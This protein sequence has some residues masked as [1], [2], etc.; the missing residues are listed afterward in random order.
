MSNN[1]TISCI[2]SVLAWENTD[3]N[4]N[5]FAEKLNNL[6][7]DSEIV[8][9]PE[10][11]TT[12]FS[13]NPG[14]LA[15]EMNCKSFA[16]MK[17]QSA[18]INKVIIGSIIIQDNNNYFNRLIAMFPNGEYFTYDKRHLFRMGKEHEK[19]TRG[20]N[21][22]VFKY[23]GWRICPLICYDLRFPVWSRNRD[24]YDMLIYIAN[25]PD[26]RRE[27][28]K[29]LL[30]ARAL[31][32]QA[33]VVGV[34]RVGEDGEGLRYSGDTMVIGP[35]GQIL[36][37]SKEYKNEIINVKVSLDELNQFREKFPVALDAD[38]FKIL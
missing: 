19:Y 3:Q 23:N 1:L 25:W 11:F 16:W 28:W 10:M 5:Q 29:N 24:D 12:G 21:R 30:I 2:Q 13:M 33:Y 20:E 36:G 9:L 18:K 34:N 22:L 15:E 37:S 31:E 27:V 35:K 6:P 38:E 8:V 4:L 14:K 7:S 17:D 32:N 26:S